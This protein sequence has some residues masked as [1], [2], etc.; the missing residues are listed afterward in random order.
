MRTPE[1]KIRTRDELARLWRDTPPAALVLANGLFDVVHVG[2]AR[3]LADARK[4]GD[5]LVV[6]LNDDHSA[7][8]NKGAKRPLVP[9][10]ERQE[11]VAAFRCVDFVTSFPETSVAE[12]FRRLRPR[13]HAKGTDYRPETLPSAEQALHAELGIDVVIV[14][15]PKDHATTDIIRRVLGG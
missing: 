1:E 10:R 14:G 2:H 13:Y 12:T 4:A 3:Y 7:R 11:I 5:L 9:L 8:R 6:A 15:D